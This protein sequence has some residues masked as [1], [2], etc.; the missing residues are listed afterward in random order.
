MMQP[1]SMTGLVFGA[2]AASAL[3]T[4]YPSLSHALLLMLCVSDVLAPWMMRSVLRGMREVALTPVQ[5]I[6]MRPNHSGLQTQSSL[7]PR[8]VDTHVDIQAVG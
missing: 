6:V 7:L 4:T 5:P 8:R 2:M 3:A 1:L